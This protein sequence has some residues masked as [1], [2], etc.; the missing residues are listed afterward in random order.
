MDGYDKMLM[1]MRK[2]GAVLNSQKLA[3]GTMTGD[4]TCEVG[5]MELDSEDLI[6][7]EHL[8]YSIC[9]DAEREE[10]IS[11]LKAGDEVVLYPIV[12]ND[13]HAVDR[14]VILEKV[15]RL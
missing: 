3:L 5:G 11:P 10:Y 8:L 9:T 14:Y 4:K 15:V 13:K 1:L 12:A 7:A 6:I 2:Q